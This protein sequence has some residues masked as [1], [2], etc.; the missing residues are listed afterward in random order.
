MALDLEIIVRD[1]ESGRVVKRYT[2]LSVT[3]RELGNIN[4][5]TTAIDYGLDV[6]FVIDSE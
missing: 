3:S 1:R 5:V 2:Q 4:K 6:D